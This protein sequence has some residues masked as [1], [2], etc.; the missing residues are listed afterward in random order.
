MRTI[1]TP[2]H[3]FSQNLRNLCK[4]LK[5]EYP[6]ETFCFASYRNH[7]LHEGALLLLLWR[8]PDRIIQIEPITMEIIQKFHYQTR[9]LETPN[10]KYI[11]ALSF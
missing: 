3:L 9:E 8:R 11:L 7:Q 1:N 10:Q 6:Q 2:L 5:S 4:S